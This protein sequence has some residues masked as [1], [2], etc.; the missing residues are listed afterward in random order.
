MDVVI[1]T[2]LILVV[3]PL[4]VFENAHR[5]IEDEDMRDVISPEDSWK[6]WVETKHIPDFVVTYCEYVIKYNNFHRFAR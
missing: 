6:L 4:D 3:T 1:K 5:F 2:A